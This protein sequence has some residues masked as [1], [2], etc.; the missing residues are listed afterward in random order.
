MKFLA[1]IGG[2]FARIGRWIRDT[3]WV[4]PLLIV[5]GI[6]GIIFS[7]IPIKNGIESLMDKG[8]PSQNYYEKY[9]LSLEGTNEGEG[10]SAADGLFRY[11]E[12]IQEA[13]GDKTQ[14]NQAD[15]NKYGEKFF[16]AF[17]QKNCAG[18]ESGYPGFNTLQK[19]WNKMGLTINDNLPYKIHTIF[20]DTIDDEDIDS[21]NLFNDYILNRYTNIFEEAVQTAQESD[22]C[23]NQATGKVTDSTYYKD[24]EKMLEE[25]SFQSPTTFLVSL[26][27]ASLG[28][29]YGIS[30]VLFDY[31]PKNGEEG[32]FRRAETLCDAWNHEGI[33]SSDYKK[34]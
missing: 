21:E 3:A 30:E 23:I 27:D 5:G 18:C 13:N 4:Q 34:N 19:N 26:Q 25:G 8:D 33:F 29:Q 16:V 11:M 22:Y 28:Y 9:K 17:V 32:N 6:F 24:A 1:A 31:A 20:I 12:D 7:I 2:F 15:V 10:E 14:L